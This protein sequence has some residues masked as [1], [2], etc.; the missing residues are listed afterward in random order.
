ML[1][2]DYGFERP[3]Y[4]QPDRREGTLRTFSKHRAA[5]DALSH[6]GEID[7][8]AHVDFTAVAEV[9]G[10]LGG[11]PRPLISQGNWLT[12]RAK[13][14]LLAQEGKPDPKAM[15]QF[16]SLTHPGHLGRSFQ[17]LEVEFS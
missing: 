11:H 4:Y 3:D 13:D 17:V 7:I 6:P 9:A 5:D 2:I 12:H 10:G 1:W 16:Q 8:S 14:W 15:R